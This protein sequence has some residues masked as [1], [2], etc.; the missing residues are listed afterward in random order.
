M[1]K[2]RKIEQKDKA[3]STRSLILE[4]SLDM[5]NK[6]GVVEFRIDSLA[7]DLG[8]SPGNITYHFSRKEDICVILWSDF[9]RKLNVYNAT[10]SSMLDVKQA[11]LIIRAI[12]KL[13]Y[14][15]RGVIMFRGGDLR[16]IHEDEDSEGGI[17]FTLL[18]RQLFERILRILRRNGYAVELTDELLKNTLLNVESILMRW[19]INKAVI[20]EDA[21]SADTDIARL[22]NRNSLLVLFAMYAV[23]TDKGMREFR[24]IAEIVNKGEMEA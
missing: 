6:I 23:F 14:D 24:A 15:Y 19:W 11:F 10:F 7:S 8:L 22:I 5:I 17:S 21:D 9:I 20:L 12:N 2:N 18:S 4:K 13:I 16:V 3:L 1:V